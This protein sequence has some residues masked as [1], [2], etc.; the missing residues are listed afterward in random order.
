MNQTLLKTLTILTFLNLGGAVMAAPIIYQNGNLNGTT[1]ANTI[2]QGFSV[3]DSFVVSSP[4][5]ATA[6]T[7]GSWTSI[8]QTIATVN[9]SISDMVQG[10]GT[11]YGSGVSV[12][13]STFNNQAFGFYDVS[14]ATFSLPGVALAAGNYFLTLNNA[15]ATD[16]SAAYWDINNGPST[17]DQNGVSVNSHFFLIAGATDAPE[18]DAGRATIPVLFVG[19]LLLTLSGRRAKT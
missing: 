16:F 10:G 8:G 17:A 9:W 11:V 14:F 19:M 3:S 1:D 18:L 7:F 15:V 5:V 6:V 13:S 12:V 2:N 4:D